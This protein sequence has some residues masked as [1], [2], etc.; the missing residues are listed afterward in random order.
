MDADA[1]PFAVLFERLKPH[2]QAATLLEAELA[3]KPA[4]ERQARAAVALVRLGRAD[5][6]WR[7]LVHSADPSVRSTIVNWLQPLGADPAA[8]A[9]KL[10]GLG[11][12]DE[13]E[14][15]A[16]DRARARMER[17]LFH[18]RTSLR[19]ALILALGHYDRSALPPRERDP[20]V[21]AL[22]EAYCDD[23]DA[24]IHGAAEWTL[25]RWNQ[26][27]TLEK[28]ALPS[29]ANRGDRRWFVTGSGQTM[30]LIE[31]PVVFAMGSPPSDPERVD[32]EIPHRK[33]INRRYAIATKEVTVDQYG[34]FLKENPK[35]APLPA[36]RYSPEPGGPMNRPTWY[37]AVAYCNWLSRQE[38][39]EECYTPNSD[40]EYAEG[41]TCAPGF[42][43]RP[44]YRLP[45]ETEWEYACR[46]GAATSRYYGRSVALLKDHAW[47]ITNSQDRAW[48]CGRLQPN[49]LGLFDMLGNVFEW[50]QE[51]YSGYPARGKEIIDDD[52]ITLLILNHK[53]EYIIRGG[54]FTSP[55]GNT[56][57]AIRIR[58]PPT[59]RTI[60][61]G[62]RVA[63]TCR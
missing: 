35:I 57:A 49:D 11:T 23:P 63:R 48:P 29:L 17:I 52:V 9:K 50:C 44:G 32:D 13:E 40:G 1:K 26:G 10:A 59:T 28:V 61:Y 8:L 39:L 21:A 37:D 16:S 24:G 5:Q 43:D 18:P 42:L 14:G 60:N 7:L 20:L 4:P 6:V 45:T 30:V 36:D 46:A 15:P 47:Y 3:K 51:R 12:E 56:R 31:G 22:L 2:P 55:A 19:R 34:R 58:N 53:D 25:R 38:G 54:A 62:F 41:M 27:E 33:R